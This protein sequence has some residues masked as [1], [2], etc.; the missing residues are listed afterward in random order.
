M[1]L[2]AELTLRYVSRL[3]AP[4]LGE[5]EVYDESYEYTVDC[6]LPVK[7]VFEDVYDDTY[8]PYVSIRREVNIDYEPNINGMRAVITK[9]RRYIGYGLYFGGNVNPREIIFTRWT[10][11][12][13]YLSY[14]FREPLRYKESLHFGIVSTKDMYARVTPRKVWIYKLTEYEPPRLSTPNVIHRQV[15]IDP[16]GGP[17]GQFGTFKYNPPLLV[18]LHGSITNEYTSRL[19]VCIIGNYDIPELDDLFIGGGTLDG[20]RVLYTYLHY[21]NHPTFRWYAILNIYDVRY[22]GGVTEMTMFGIDN[23][24]VVDPY[25]IFKHD[26]YIPDMIKVNASVYIL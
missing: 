25:F 9:N 7:I 19:Y 3:F 5:E 26:A 6:V 17:I 1:S 8:F 22:I 2:I 20:T 11:G 24:Y 10:A 21:A 12:H 23:K 14:R 18:K 4:S 16:Y 15:R 13:E